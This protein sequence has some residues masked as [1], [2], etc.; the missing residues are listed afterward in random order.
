MSTAELKFQIISSINEIDDIS[1][2]DKVKKYLKSLNKSKKNDNSELIEELKTSF[3]ELK[4]V[5]EGKL[6]T[7]SAQDLLDEL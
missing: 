2:L 5:K 4:L 6:K 7:R 1:L 3:E